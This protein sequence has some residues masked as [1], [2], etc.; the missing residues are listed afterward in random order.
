MIKYGIMVVFLLAFFCAGT[1][2]AYSQVQVAPIL[3]KSE[4][5]KT[6]DV[7]KDGKP[8]VVYHSDGKYTSKIE[9]DTNYDGQYDITIYTK[10]GNF[11]SAEADTDYDGQTDKKFSNVKEFNQW[12]NEKHPD[13][14]DQLNRPDW[15]FDLI[16]F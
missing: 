2:P 15:Q 7:N 16:K 6:L 10:D 11:D 12:L 9:A 1:Y 8:D 3:P 13:F 14:E 4:E 5:I